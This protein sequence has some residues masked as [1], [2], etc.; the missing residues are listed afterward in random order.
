ML[1]EKGQERLSKRTFKRIYV[2]PLGNTLRKIPVDDVIVGA[3]FGRPDWQ[4]AAFGRRPQVA[5]TKL[6]VRVKFVRMSLVVIQNNQ[7]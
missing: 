7:T 3:T 5:P 6:S 2:K 1:K 4:S